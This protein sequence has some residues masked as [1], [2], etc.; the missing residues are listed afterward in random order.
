MG[1]TPQRLAKEASLLNLWGLSPATISSVA[2]WSVPMPGKETN[3]GAACATSRS[4]SVRLE[5]GDLSRE[6]L[7]TASHRTERELLGCRRYLT[8]VISEAEACSH[9]DEFLGRESAQTVAE[10]VRCRHPQ[11]LELALA[12]CVLAFIAERR[13]VRRAR[14]ISTQPSPLFLGTPHVSPANT[15]RAALSALVGS[16]LM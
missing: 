1:E 10:F 16:D 8:K 7:V 3:S 2:A 11:A 13:T 15:A 14:I 6:S 4:S 12:A 5:L 9:G